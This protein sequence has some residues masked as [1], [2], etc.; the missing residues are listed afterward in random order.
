MGNEHPPNEAVGLPATLADRVTEVLLGKIRNG[1]FA[2]GDRLPSEAALALRFSV[3]RTVIREAVSRLKAEGLVATHQGKGTLIVGP[4]Q[5]ARFQIDVDVD[6]SVP[7]VLRV[8]ESRRSAG[9]RRRTPRSSARCARSTLRWR[10]D[11]MVSTRTWLF[12]TRSPMRLAIRCT[13]RY[14]AFCASSCARRSRWDA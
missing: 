11:T 5:S 14:W 3:S 13:P 2:A 4:T 10:P 12:I 6:G 1:E 9:P 8:M 7:A